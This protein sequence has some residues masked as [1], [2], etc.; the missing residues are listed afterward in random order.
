MA[1]IYTLIWAIS[2]ANGF[3]GVVQVLLR[4]VIALKRCCGRGHGATRGEGRMQCGRRYGRNMGAAAGVV[5]GIP[6]GRYV[7]VRMMVFKGKFR[8][9]PSVKPTR[10]YINLKS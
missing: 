7:G 8:H 4:A 1:Q 3:T 9:H 10:N 2:G 5:M 6:H